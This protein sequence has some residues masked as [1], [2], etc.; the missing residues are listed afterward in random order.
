MSPL[1]CRRGLVFRAGLRWPRRRVA[2]PVSPRPSISRWA[3]VAARRAARRRVWVGRGDFKRKPRWRVEALLLAGAVLCWESF[4]EYYFC[5]LLKK[6]AENFDCVG[7]EM[8][9]YSFA[10]AGMWRSTMRR[11][12]FSSPSSVW[13]AE[14][15][16]PQDSMPIMG[17]GGR[18]RMAMQVLP[19]SSSGSE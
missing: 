10:P 17:R 7:G 3:S 18:F 5:R 16:M 1:P 4:E 13:T 2:A 12:S 14:I 15:S 6:A 8:V 11:W 9:Q 19:M